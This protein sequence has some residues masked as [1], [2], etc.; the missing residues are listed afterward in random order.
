MALVQVGERGTDPNVES[1]CEYI[2]KA[3]ADSRQGVVLKVGVG[4]GKNTMFRTILKC[5]G[6]GLILWY[7]VSNGKGAWNLRRLGQG[8]LT[9]TVATE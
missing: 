4:R 8:H 6:L 3:V 1:N 7:D 5:L 2:E 9:A